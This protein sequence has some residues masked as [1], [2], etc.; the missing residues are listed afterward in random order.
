MTADV[1]VRAKRRLKEMEAKGVTT[2]LEDVEADIRNRD[3]LDSTRKESPLK[4]AEDAIVVDTS[5]LTIE[6]QVGE[7]LKL[8]KKKIQA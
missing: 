3:H 6:Q 1:T 5:G 7:A 8:A 4:K 2:N